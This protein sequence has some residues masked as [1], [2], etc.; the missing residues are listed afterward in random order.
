MILWLPN[1]I[2]MIFPAAMMGG[3]IFQ[4]R[5]GWAALHASLVAANLCFAIGFYRM[6]RPHDEG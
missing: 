2:S 3:Y 1:T 6:G 4:G 5:Y